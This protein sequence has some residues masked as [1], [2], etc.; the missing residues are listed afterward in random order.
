ME[1]TSPCFILPQISLFA[2][3]VTPSLNPVLH[4][5]M[6]NVHVSLQNVN[7]VQNTHHNGVNDDARLKPCHTFSTMQ[8]IG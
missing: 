1:D 5:T 3:P 2:T 4:F 8:L 6:H 7:F